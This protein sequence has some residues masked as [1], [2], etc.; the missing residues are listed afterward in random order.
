MKFIYSENFHTKYSLIGKYIV[1]L[2][3][4]KIGEFNKKDYDPIFYGVIDIPSLEKLTEAY[5]TNPDEFRNLTENPYSIDELLKETDGNQFLLSVIGMETTNLKTIKSLINYGNGQIVSDMIY[6]NQTVQKSLS[7]VDMIVKK[8]ADDNE[9]L[10]YFRE[11]NV[12]NNLPNS[13]INRLFDIG[14]PDITYSL[15]AYDRLSKKD[16]EPLFDSDN[17]TILTALARFAKL[18]ESQREK[19]SHHPEE[20]V[21]LAFRRRD[22][23]RLEEDKYLWERIIESQREYEAEMERQREIKRQERLEWEKKIEM[24]LAAERQQAQ[25]AEAGI[26]KAQ[27]IK[28]EHIEPTI[29]KP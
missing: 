29:F 7:L 24:E 4:N 28:I 2:S 15:I 23:L 27:D 25:Q 18:N 8:Y 21:W 11:P 16:L 3:Q 9:V 13:I 17:L 14:S 20:D 26:G 12:M 6:S 10:S 1:N 19:F 5:K 22:D